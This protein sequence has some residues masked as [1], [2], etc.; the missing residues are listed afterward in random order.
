M[1]EKKIVDELKTYV[2][3][4]TRTVRLMDK[5]EGAEDDTIYKRIVLENSFYIDG[6]ICHLVIERANKKEYIGDITFTD[7]KK[8]YTGKLRDHIE[9]ELTP[10]VIKKYSGKN[11]IFY[12]SKPFRLRAQNSANRTGYGT[13]WD[14]SYGIGTIVYEGT[15]YGETTDYVFSGAYIE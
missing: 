1:A 12:F 5:F 9:S 13:E 3:E 4:D 7:F 11:E 2:F 15:L 14:W 6:A 10:D 8:G